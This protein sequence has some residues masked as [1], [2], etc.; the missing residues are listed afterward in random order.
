[1]ASLLRSRNAQ[2]VINQ[3]SQGVRR[4]RL[5]RHFTTIEKNSGRA[6]HT[7]GTRAFTVEKDSLLDPI[8]SQIAFVTFDIETDLLRITFKGRPHIKL[9][10]PLV[11]I[12]KYQCVHFPELTLHARS[13]SRRR[14]R[15]SVIV[16]RERKLSEN[17]LQLIAKL[18]MHLLQYR[19]KQSAWRTLKITKLLDLHRCI[20]R[21]NRMR[22][23]SARNPSLDRPQSRRRFRGGRV[24]LRLICVLVR[25]GFCLRHVD[26]AANGDAKHAEDDDER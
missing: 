17:D 23:V 3:H 8:A 18:V 6:I 13:L 21:P 1:M 10:L 16:V 24:C 15:Y 11:L 9:R 14:S 2:F 20:R 22:R 7:H 19:M 25:G 12:L 5:E 26:D 4:Q